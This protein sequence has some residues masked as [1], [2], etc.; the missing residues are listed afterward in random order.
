MDNSN[1]FE[2]IENLYFNNKYEE[3]IGFWEK[4][5]SN[6]SIDNKSEY[7]NKI[8][9]AVATSYFET[10]MFVNSLKYL[11]KQI[12]QLEFLEIPV[13]EKEKK[14]RY[15]YLNKVNIFSKQ[16]KRV[17]EYRTIWEYIQKYKND[18][19]FLELS[20]SLEAN[21]YNKYVVF[22]RYFRY[23]ILC[24]III[25]ILLHLSSISI[26]NN[27]YNI[28][29]VF[30][31]I[32]IAWIVFNLLLPHLIKKYFLSGVRYFLRPRNN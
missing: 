23:L 17:T 27:L 18:K 21:F 4:H 12:K 22:N 9:E 14:L 25:A 24:L 28:Y 11:D 7:Y 32:A 31:I 10:G 13:H 6:Y 29:N 16:E 1:I 19:T 2:T 8:L 3:V 15:Y 30:S 20:D 26:N 5:K